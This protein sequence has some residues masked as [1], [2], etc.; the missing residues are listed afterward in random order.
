M[1]IL[2]CTHYLSQVL[3]AKPFIQS[4][5]PFKHRIQLPLG[6]I[7]Q[8]QIKV[9]IVLIMIIQLDDMIM[10]QVVHDLDFELDLLN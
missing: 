9:V 10:I 7:L 6:T 4:S 1:Q 5:L 8:N 2:D 3:G